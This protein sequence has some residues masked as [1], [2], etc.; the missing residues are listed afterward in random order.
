MIVSAR[1]APLVLS[2]ALKRIVD[3]EAMMLRGEFGEGAALFAN[4]QLLEAQSTGQPAAVLF[5]STLLEIISQAP[6]TPALSLP[7]DADLVRSAKRSIARALLP[8][9]VP[10]AYAR[11]RGR[12]NSR[13]FALRH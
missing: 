8:G 5:W 13:K 9:D 3:E 1:M 4:G 10:A 6:A 12:R 2:P 7:T 11:A